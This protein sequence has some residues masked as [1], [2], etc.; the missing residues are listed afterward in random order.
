MRRL[1]V[2]YIV[3]AAIGLCLLAAG[4]ILSRGA[5]F[6][7]LGHLA[8]GLTI[9]LTAAL[10]SGHVAV[11]LGQPAVLGELLAGIVIGNA[12]GLGPLRFLGADRYLDILSQL[13][14]LLLLFEVGLALSVRDLFTVGASSFLVALLGSA[15]SLAA[16]TG[17]A[18]LLMAGAPLAARVFL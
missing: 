4:L 17:A 8:L 13:G 1:P 16:G 6:D 2:L 10:F 5:S 14:M 3:L 7:E 11:R 9:V 18:W 15:G 12:P